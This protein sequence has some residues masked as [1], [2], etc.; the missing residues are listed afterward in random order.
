MSSRD[1]HDATSGQV[2]DELG[3]R[4]RRRERGIV[5]GPPQRVDHGVPGHVDGAGI[6]ALAHQR[7]GRRPGGR[8]VLIRDRRD[9]PPVDLLGPGLE[10]IAGAQPGLHMTDRHLV[11]VGGERARHRRRRIALDHHAIRPLV[12]DHVVQSRQ[13]A[14]SQ[15]IQG[16]PMPHQ[17]EVDVGNDACDLQHLI[18]QAAVLG[19]GAGADADTGRR[20]QRADDG[21]E[22]EGFGTRPEDDQNGTAHGP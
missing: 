20:V 10:D 12:T 21:K 9:D 4:G 22:L 2:A 7:L 14:R 5:A 17:I 18:Q 19:G 15:P 3:D 6:D 1:Q 8:E 13:R 16:L 11:I